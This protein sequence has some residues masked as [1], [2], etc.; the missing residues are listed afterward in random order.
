VTHAVR[1]SMLAL[2]SFTVAEITTKGHSRSSPMT[3]ILFNTSLISAS[4]STLDFATVMTW[5]CYP[6]GAEQKSRKW[7]LSLVGQMASCGMRWP[8]INGPA[9]VSRRQICKCSH[10]LGTRN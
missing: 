8:V 6:R 4:A 2:G 5:P 7:K 3:C 9:E 10:K 1:F